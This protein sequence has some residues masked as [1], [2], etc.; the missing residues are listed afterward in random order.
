MPEPNKTAI[1]L[2]KD[3][4]MS[5]VFGTARMYTKSFLN[6]PLEKILGITTFE[7]G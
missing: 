6:L 3:F 5:P 7:L 4:G 1:A 2:V